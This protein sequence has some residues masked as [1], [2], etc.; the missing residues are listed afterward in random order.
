MENQH[1]HSHMNDGVRYTIIFV[2]IFSFILALSYF[3]DKI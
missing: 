3:V 2:A 1:T